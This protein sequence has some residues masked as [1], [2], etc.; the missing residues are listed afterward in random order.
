MTSHISVGQTRILLIEDNAAQ[1]ELLGQALARHNLAGEPRT[2]HD[3]EAALAFLEGEVARPVPRLPHLILL[4]LKL[5]SGSGLDLLRRL[6]AHPHLA[7]LPVVILTTS[8]DAR[9][10]R[11]SYAEGANGYVV[12]PDTFAQLVAMAGDLCRFW[13]GWNRPAPLTR[14]HS[15][16][17]D[18]TT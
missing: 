15:G 16:H 11:A 3:P 13:L 8:D 12:K 7:L 6:R 18:R 17:L 14:T 5:A 10:L 1:C 2:E 9:D 4:D